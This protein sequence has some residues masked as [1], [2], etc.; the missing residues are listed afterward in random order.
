M[1][2]IKHK[3]NVRNIWPSIIGHWSFRAKGEEG[4]S[5]YM[6][7]VILGIVF[8]IGFSIAGLL[9]GEIKIARNINNF[10]PAI[11]AADSGMERALYKSRKTEVFA[12][13]NCG[14]SDTPCVVDNSSGP[15]FNNGA[16]Y[17]AT[18]KDNSFATCSAGNQCIKSVGTKEN[19]NRAFGA[20]Y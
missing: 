13:G 14:P 6:T 7:I 18:I 16:A 17:S 9:I 20:T 8:S 12:P 5:L 3:K 19:T 4:V 11:Y 1:K 15:S 10:V 2:Y